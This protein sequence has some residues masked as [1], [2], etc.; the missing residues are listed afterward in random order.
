MM[1]RDGAVESIMPLCPG[2]RFNVIQ[3]RRLC[4]TGAHVE[5]RA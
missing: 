2:Q 3:E 4:A 5:L 1:Y